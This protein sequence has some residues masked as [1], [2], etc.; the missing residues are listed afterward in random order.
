MGEVGLSEGHEPGVKISPN[1]EKK[2]RNGREILVGDR[3]DYGESEINSKGNFGVR[4]PARFVVVFFRNKS[5]FFAFNLKFWSAC[6]LAFHSEDGFE[7]RLGI[8]DGNADAG[9]HDE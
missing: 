5:I 1:E 2:E 8:P 4:H 7:H 6:E 9:G 3:V